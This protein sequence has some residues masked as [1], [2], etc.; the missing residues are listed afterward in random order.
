LILVYHNRNAL[1][2][3][4]DGD[5]VGLCIRGHFKAAMNQR[6][7]SMEAVGGEGGGRMSCHQAAAGEP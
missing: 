2:V 7:A 5:G 4:E 3:V 6:S 1:A